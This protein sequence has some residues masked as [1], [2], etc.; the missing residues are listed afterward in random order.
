MPS[1]F[2]GMDPFIEG[3]SWSDFHHRFITAL[4]D[5]LV[6]KVRP[7]YIT[8]IEERVY[9]E[10]ELEQPRMRFRPDVA[11]VSKSAGEA[12]APHAAGPSAE[13]IQVPILMPDPERE[14]FLELRL[15]S[16]DELIA[17]IELLSPANKRPHSDGRREYLAKRNL[18]LPGTV[19][20]VELDLLRGGERLPM[21]GSLPPAYGY[22]IVSKS[23]RRPMAEV[24]PVAL[25]NPLP[26]ISMPLAGGDPA[27]Q[28]DLQAVFNSVYDRAAYDLAIKY[29]KPLD[30]PLDG[31]DAEWV[32]GIIAAGSSDDS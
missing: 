32:R 29:G 15:A 3:Q 13:P 25:R 22:A 21:A 7:R 14:P 9:V 18:I 19:H 26:T 23:T 10:R 8:R 28:V 1:P 31:E 11:V 6:P 4:S 20:L 17:V 30:P 2:P 24:W 12:P 5:D 27:V 16:D